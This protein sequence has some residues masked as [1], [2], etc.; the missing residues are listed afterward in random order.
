MEK[1]INHLVLIFRK[2]IYLEIQEGNT[3]SIGLATTEQIAI[4]SLKLTDFHL[5][6]WLAV[7][8]AHMHR[9]SYILIPRLWMEIEYSSLGM[10]LEALMLA[11]NGKRP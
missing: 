6:Y 11:D 1:K 10:K 9:K 2:N 8:G 7:V 5:A 4:V 3:T